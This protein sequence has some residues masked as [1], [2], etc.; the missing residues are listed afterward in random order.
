MAE[1]REELRARHHAALNAKRGTLRS[2]PVGTAKL[3][4]Q[5]VERFNL[6]RL[7]ESEGSQEKLAQR[8]AAR[9]DAPDRLQFLPLRDAFRRCSRWRCSIFSSSPISPGRG[10]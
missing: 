2:E 4:K 9:P 3:I 7:V 5:I 1:R 10:R 8:R 6:A